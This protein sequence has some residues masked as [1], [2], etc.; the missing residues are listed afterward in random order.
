MPGIN[1][2][3]LVVGDAD[4]LIALLHEEDALFAQAKQTVEYLVAHD[5]HVIFPVTA[6][7][8][9]ITTFT[10]KLNKPKL[11]AQVV[12]RLKHGD[13]LIEAVDSAIFDE[14]LGLFNPNASKK[15]TI[16]DACVAA[17]A[18]KLHARCIFSFDGWYTTLGYTL[19]RD[20]V[21]DS[22]TS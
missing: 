2:P 14:A 19:A 8:E 17:T 16:F 12:D 4:G 21:K 10:R 5:A 3:F 15:R 7:A 6:I 11:A 20:L 9:A 22:T 18:Q 13:L 1:A